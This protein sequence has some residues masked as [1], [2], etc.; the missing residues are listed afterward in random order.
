MWKVDDK[1]SA[2]SEECAGMSSTGYVADESF[3]TLKKVNAL[4]NDISE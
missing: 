4:A 3:A 1:L 2:R